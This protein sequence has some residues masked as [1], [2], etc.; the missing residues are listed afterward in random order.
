MDP[1]PA[2]PKVSLVPLIDDGKH[3]LERLGTCPRSQGCMILKTF[4]CKSLYQAAYRARETFPSE[5]L[6]IRWLMSTLKSVP[7]PGCSRA[8]LK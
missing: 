8:L 6:Q 1:T 4:I 7:S 3:T 2:V 5:I